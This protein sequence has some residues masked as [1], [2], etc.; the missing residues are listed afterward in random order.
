ML[1]SR[2]VTTPVSA[3]C[4]HPL[5]C[6][7]LSAA[8]AAAEWTSGRRDGLYPSVECTRAAGAGWRLER[9]ARIFLS[10]GSGV[11]IC[12]AFY[13]AFVRPLARRLPQN[14][15]RDQR[16]LNSLIEGV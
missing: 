9:T 5:L 8:A 3:F 10:V 15:S 7:S 12:T 1:Y 13:V 4:D 14:V 11:L 2:R 6:I 16:R